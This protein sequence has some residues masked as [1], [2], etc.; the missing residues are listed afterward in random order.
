MARGMPSTID[1]VIIGTSSVART[2]DD[3]TIADQS[4]TSSQ[5]TGPRP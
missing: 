5:G 3:G 2:R 4:L 1:T